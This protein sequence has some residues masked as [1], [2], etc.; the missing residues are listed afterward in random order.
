MAT[1][2]VITTLGSANRKIPEEDAWRLVLKEWGDVMDGYAEA[3]EGDESWAYNE[4]ASL[5]TLTAAI[6]RSNRANVVL[7]EYRCDKLRHTG[8]DGAPA[9]GKGRA[10]L[11]TMVG[12]ASFLMESKFLWVS[13]LARGGGF[14]RVKA[15]VAT[16]FSQVQRYEDEA[17]QLAVAVF[18]V[19][20]MKPSN[21]EAAATVI[22]RV[23]EWPIALGNRVGLR[24]DYYR[25]AADD[26]DET[27]WRFPGVTLFL[28]FRAQ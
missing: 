18:A 28:L 4:R 21:T 22:K 7:E 1:Q 24:A 25:G 10:D 17:D 6:S 27:A 5:S 13:S 8:E 14:G 26:D 16:A 19:P 9:W 3:T 15:I 11:W 2:V 12:T 20:Y 23:R